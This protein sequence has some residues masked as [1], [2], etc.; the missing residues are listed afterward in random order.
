MPAPAALC[1]T[2]WAAQAQ[3]FPS[4]PVRLVVTYPPGGSSDLMARITAEKLRALWGHQV[5]V[6]SKPGAA[7]ARRLHL[8]RR[9][10]G[11]G[12]GQA[13]NDLLGGQ[14]GFMNS[15]ARPVAQFI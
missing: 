1:A 3:A 15:D 14:L 7:G 5:L 11:P 12:G 9:Q 8:C 6:E 4:K 2:P 13:L 10:P